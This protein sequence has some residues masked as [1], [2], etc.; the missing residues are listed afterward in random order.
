MVT[1]KTLDTVQVSDIINVGIS[2]ETAAQLHKKVDEIIK[3]YG[4]GCPETWKEISTRVLNPDLP[5]GFH[6]MMFYG[7]YKEFGP[8]PIAWLPDL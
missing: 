5:F 1:Y 7:C 6:Q 3:K 4:S 8:D 2:P